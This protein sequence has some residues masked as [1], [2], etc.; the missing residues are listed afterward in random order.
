MKRW[1]MVMVVIVVA[2]FLIV[3]S[4][5]NAKSKKKMDDPV[6]RKWWERPKIV[7]KLGL[8]GDQ[9]TRV[10]EIYNGEY[11]RIVEGRWNYKEQKSKLEDLLSK[12]DLDEEQI[13]KQTEHLQ[14]AR[15]NLEETATRM[16]TEMMKE[17]SPEQRRKL[18]AILKTWKD[19]VR[20]KSK[21]HRK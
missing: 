6:I 5:C 10:K 2:M 3:P 13:G 20:H 11:D 17:L 19:E 14:A 18:L 7:Q 16:Q 15:A 8:T 12:T 9:L 4:V 21:K 1:T